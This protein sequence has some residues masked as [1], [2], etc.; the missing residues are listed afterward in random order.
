MNVE[1][2]ELA[3]ATE[4]A[5]P[6][7]LTSFGWSPDGSYLGLSKIG[8]EETATIAVMDTVT[9]E[10]RTLVEEEGVAL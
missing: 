2:R 8:G 3:A 7:C 6:F 10:L 4:T 9:G 5:C 1:V